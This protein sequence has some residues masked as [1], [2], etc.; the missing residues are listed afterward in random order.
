MCEISATNRSAKRVLDTD[1]LARGADLVVGYLC[2]YETPPIVR[3]WTVV[4]VAHSQ[5]LLPLKS[6][7][8]EPGTVD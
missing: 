6:P 5:S 7:L 3:S 8:M 2:G 4:R 1:Y